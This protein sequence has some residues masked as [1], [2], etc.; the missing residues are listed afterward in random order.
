MNNIGVYVIALFFTDD[1]DKNMRYVF[2][3]TRVFSVLIKIISDISAD[4]QSCSVFVYPDDLIYF[5]LSGLCLTEGGGD[6]F[7]GHSGEF[8]FPGT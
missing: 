5:L 3:R 1:D 4:F 2:S 6:K 7:C 8:S